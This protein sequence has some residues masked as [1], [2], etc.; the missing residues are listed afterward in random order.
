MPPTLA[1]LGSKYATVVISP[2]LK[3]SRYPALARMDSLSMTPMRAER[4]GLMNLYETSGTP[5]LELSAGGG[6]I[7]TV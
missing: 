1:T 2:E 3:T 7:S 5:A 6:G 4:L